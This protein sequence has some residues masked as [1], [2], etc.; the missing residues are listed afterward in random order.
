M[1]NLN[2]RWIPKF[3][4]F[5]KK[6][7]WKVKHLLDL[8]TLIVMEHCLLCSRQR[9]DIWIAHCHYIP[10]LWPFLCNHFYCWPQISDCG[11]LRVCDVCIVHC[12]H[13]QPQ[14]A[15][16]GTKLV[17]VKCS[18]STFSNFVA[19]CLEMILFLKFTSTCYNPVSRESLLR[20]SNSWLG[21]VQALSAQ[22]THIMC[23]SR[24]ACMPG[25][26]HCLQ[27]NQMF[28]SVHTVFHMHHS[29]WSALSH[30]N[31]SQGCIKDQPH[32]QK[33]ANL[34]YGH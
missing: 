4:Q 9:V 6:N 20:Q 5:C 8:L 12:Y 18:V 7:F 14:N 16:K 22:F 23:K 13:M 3:F 24:T 19:F 27:C 31:I 25:S 30:R 34:P 17:V 26:I 10:R 11:H 33:C 1:P 32:A 15:E 29:Y 2:S 28:A 21:S